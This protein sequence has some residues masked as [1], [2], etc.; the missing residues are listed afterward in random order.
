MNDLWRFLPGPRRFVE[1]VVKNFK[2]GQNV[3][4]CLPY[5]APYGLKQA[6]RDDLQDLR[7]LEWSTL[8]LPDDPAITPISYLSHHFFEVP[9]GS[10]AISI[11]SLSQNEN[12]NGRL[13]WVEGV[14]KANWPQWRSF[15]ADYEHI[16]R[17]KQHWCQ[18]L[19]CVVLEGELT[20][21]PPFD[22]LCLVTHE[23]NGVINAIDTLIYAT[24]LV[25]GMRCSVTQRQIAVAI[26]ANLSMWDL[27][28]C[29]RLSAEKL[30]VIFEPFG[31][32][33]DIAQE[34]DWLFPKGGEFT[35]LK[36]HSGMK[37]KFNG[38][39]QVNSI[40]YS[41]S[42]E[43]DKIAKRMWSAQVGVL[44]P[45]IEEMRYEMLPKIKKYVTLPH[46]T[47]YGTINDLYDLEIGH[48]ESQLRNRND[49]SHTFKQ[50]LSVLKNIRN[51]LAH[52]TPIK[53][54]LLLNSSLLC[55]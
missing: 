2:E 6:I 19:F 29:E 45:F 21:D 3:L 52:L 1:N 43:V 23:L 22:E 47:D 32:L 44:L 53:T 39:Q 54:S 48:I 33:R 8:T 11:S 38:K 55:E 41:G 37:N 36:W 27:D 35:T 7:M 16:C 34:R 42:D 9:V 28:L 4:L 12:F 51:D 14:N 50:E 30:Q 5:Y 24:T 13:I 15:L 49:V 46:V 20:E 26:L 31:L 40:V 18:S 25:S 17:N 10:K